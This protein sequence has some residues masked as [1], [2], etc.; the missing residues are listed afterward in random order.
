MTLGASAHQSKRSIS[1]TPPSDASLP[2]GCMRT[3]VPQTVGSPQRLRPGVG[4]SFASPC[5]VAESLVSHDVPWFPAAAATPPGVFSLL[6]SSRRLPRAA[7]FR[8]GQRAQMR[9]GGRVRG[10]QR[11]RLILDY[12]PTEDRGRKKSV[13]RTEARPQ[14]CHSHVLQVHEGV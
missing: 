1:A 4:H 7:L 5:V 12:P 3:H 10:E 14:A 9:W 6:G 8:D 2:R 13:P 11:A